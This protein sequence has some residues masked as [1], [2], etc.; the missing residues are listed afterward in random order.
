MTECRSR[1]H[2]QNLG[3]PSKPPLPDQP[4]KH[5]GACASQARRRSTL[6][7]YQETCCV[8]PVRLG[9][10]CEPDCVSCQAERC[11]GGRLVADLRKHREIDSAWAA[12]LQARTAYVLP[13]AG[14][15]AS[16]L[17]RHG[18]AHGPTG[19]WCQR[20]PIG[21]FYRLITKF[22]SIT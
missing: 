22:P 3:R 21:R 20:A 13:I 7:L 1:H 19:F 17:G 2:P 5:D 4:S 6:Q 9:R 8:D 10:T 15:N 12:L 14:G 18:P 16:E 11:L